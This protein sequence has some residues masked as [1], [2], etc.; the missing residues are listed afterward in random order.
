MPW[1]LGLVTLGFCYVCLFSWVLGWSILISGGC[2]PYNAGSCPHLHPSELLPCDPRCLVPGEA[3]G[4]LPGA[5]CLGPVMLLP[6]LGIFISMLSYS[7]PWITTSPASASMAGAAVLLGWPRQALCQEVVAA[8]LQKSLVPWC[9]SSTRWQ[10][11]WCPPAA[12]GSALPG[13]PR[14]VKGRLCPLP[15]PDLMV[16]NML[17]LC[18]RSPWSPLG[19]EPWAVTRPSPVLQEN[20]IHPSCSFKPW[21]SATSSSLPGFPTCLFWECHSE[22]LEEPPNAN[23]NNKTLNQPISEDSDDSGSNWDVSY[24]SWWQKTGINS[25]PSLCW[26]LQIHTYIMHTSPL[27]DWRISCLLWITRLFLS[28][29]HYVRSM[30]STDTEKSLLTQSQNQIMVWGEVL[31]EV[32][33]R[34]AKLEIGLV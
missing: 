28:Q 11:G 5:A 4:C 29:W 2:S 8:S 12:P 9:C 18:C 27:L 31:A 13:L 20:S 32:P 22:L 30:C 15:C 34:E 33:D 14:G 6:P 26:F 3:V 1:V 21:A 25:L 24:Y 7:L 23:S 10:G 16:S 17:S 19:S